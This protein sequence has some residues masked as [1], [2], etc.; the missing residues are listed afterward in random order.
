MQQ[1]KSAKKSALWEQFAY[2]LTIIIAELAKHSLEYG[3]F[4]LP[5]LP[6][7]IQQRNS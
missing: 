4:D 7:Q 5:Y 2:E 3:C 6:E 1:T